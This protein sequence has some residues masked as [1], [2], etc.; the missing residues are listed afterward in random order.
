MSETVNKPF[1][2]RMLMQTGILLLAS[3]IIGLGV[4]R[5]RS[6]GIKIPGDWSQKAQLILDTGENIGIS[7][8]EAQKVFEN[9]SALFL[10]ARPAEQYAEGHI[11]GARNLPPEAFDVHFEKVM[12]NVGTEQMIITYCD[13]ETCNLSKQLA[14]NL[15]DLGFSAVRVLPNGWSRWQG[16]RLPIETGNPG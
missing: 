1:I 2:V 6:D 15:K 7:L 8:E 3:V 16:R 11:R 5:L 4:N 9:Q 10:D 14:L 12:T 13:G